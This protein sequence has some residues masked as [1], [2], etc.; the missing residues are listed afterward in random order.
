MPSFVFMAG[1]AMPYSY[2]AGLARGESYA[3][4]ALHALYRSLVLILLGS[5]GFLFLGNWIMLKWPAHIN[6]QFQ[7]ILPQLGLAYAPAFLLL[8]R[9]ARAQL[10]AAAVILVAWW[11]AFALYPLPGPG[12]DYASVGAVGERF[13]GFFAHWNKNTN[14]AADF[15][16]WFLNLIPR[17][18]PFR[19]DKSGLTTL[20]FVPT[21]ATVIFGMRTGEF[22]RAPGEPASKVKALLIAALACLAGGIALRFTVCPMVKSLWTPSWAVYSTGWVLLMLAAFFWLIEVRGWRRASLALAVVG[23]NA[24]AVYCMANL[25]DYWI[26]KVWERSLGDYLFGGAYAPIWKSL[27][28]VV[29]LWVASVALYRRRIFF[30]I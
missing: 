16:R 2:A 18:E 29:T 30:R 5:V 25:F 27:A 20:A 14:P 21:L 6:V 24:I 7:T 1:V 3:S 4:L 17:S 15:D 11:L 9:S 19:F 13:T 10:A 22:L 28:I 26:L 12:F 23:M 8:G